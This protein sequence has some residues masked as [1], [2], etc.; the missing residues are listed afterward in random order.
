MPFSVDKAYFVQAT[1]DFVNPV[2]IRPKFDR[3]LISWEDTSR[4]KVV[5]CTKVTFDNKNA[6]EAKESIPKKIVVQSK[7]DGEYVLTL[8]TKEVFDKFVKDRVAGPL[9]FDNDEAVQKYYLS[10]NFYET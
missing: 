9:E 8:L 1:E 6:D 10:T 4:G 2:A 5:E 3:G 7:E